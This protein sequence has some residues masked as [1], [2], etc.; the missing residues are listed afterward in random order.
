MKYCEKC[1]TPLEDDAV[2]CGACGEACEGEAPAAQVQEVVE[3]PPVTQESVQQMPVEQPTAYPAE[4]EPQPE[5]KSGALPVILAIATVVLAVIGIVAALMLLNNQFHFFGGDEQETTPTTTTAKKDNVTYTGDLPSGVVMT[6]DGEEIDEKLYKAMLFDTFSYMYYEQ[7]FYQYEAYGMDVWGSENFVIHGEKVNLEDYIRI[8]AKDSLVRQIVV[9]DMMKEFGIEVDADELASYEASLEGA[10][11]QMAELGFDKASYLK[12]GTAMLEET[13]LFY[14]LYGKDGARAVSEDDL[15]AQY[16]S[17]YMNAYIKAY[18]ASSVTEEQRAELNTMLENSKTA[19]D[20]QAIFGAG[21][22]VAFNGATDDAELGKAIAS[23]EVGSAAIVEYTDGNGKAQVALI[24][25]EPIADM[26]DE[27]RDTCLYLL[28]FKEYDAEVE[29][30]MEKLTVNCDDKLIASI[31]PKDF[32]QTEEEDEN[33]NDAMSSV[34]TVTSVTATHYATI[35]IE[36]YGTIKVALDETTAPITVANFKKLAD[37]GFYNGLTFHRIM[38]GFMMQGGDPKG[39]GTGGS[40]EEI[41][42]EFAANGVENPLSHV[43]GAISMARGGHSMDSASSQFFIVHEDSVFLDG[44]YAAFGYVVEG[45]DVVD[46][47]CAAAKPIDDNGTIPAENQPV[48][49]SVTVTEA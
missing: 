14:T 30:R 49:T 40:D 33:K 27:E 36:N 17:N 8:T 45:M 37:E 4:E 38:D 3:Q 28:K 2:F 26:G 22:L 13:T 34:G 23:V 21:A 11:A 1:G 25:R 46:A 18:E 48:I 5:A 20:L 12:V 15:N 6:V 7:G 44:Q 9:R 39:N 24:A 42:G 16:N 47:V 29:E 19:T 35:V 32:L 41:K 31:S 43:R 10:D